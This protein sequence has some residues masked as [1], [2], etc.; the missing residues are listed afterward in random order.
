MITELVVI[1][2]SA[3]VDEI[4]V[5]AWFKPEGSSIE[6]GA[7]LVEITTDKACIEIDAP[8]SGTLLKILAEE[9]SIVP[10]GFT[11]A[12]IGDPEDSLPD[13]AARNKDLLEAHKRSVRPARKQHKPSKPH[14]EATTKTRATPAA[15][16]LARKSGLDLED[17]SK[18]LQTDVITENTLR[19]YL[20][21]NDIDKGASA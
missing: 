2:E 18:I 4:T 6:Q 20:D 8:V 14:D 15:R 5:T 3:N 13:V 11:L 16:R 10:I 21:A 1:R 9:K 7:P 12:L 19:A 17:L